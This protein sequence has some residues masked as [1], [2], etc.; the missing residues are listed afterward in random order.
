MLAVGRGAGR[1]RP[2][3]ALVYGEKREKARLHEGIDGEVMLKDSPLD[4]I[5]D[6]VVHRIVDINWTERTTVQT[7]EIIGRCRGP[8]CPFLH[9]RYDDLSVLGKKD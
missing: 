5:A 2:G 9:Q 6:L 1:A 3:P 4:P 7:G 8:T